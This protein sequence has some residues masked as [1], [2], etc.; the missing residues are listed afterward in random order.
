MSIN[1]MVYERSKGYKKL[2]KRCLSLFCRLPS[3][4]DVTLDLQ[5]RFDESVS[6]QMTKVTSHCVKTL[7][8]LFAFRDAKYSK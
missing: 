6:F 8:V 5:N 4:L 7:Q 3:K 2:P 1:Q